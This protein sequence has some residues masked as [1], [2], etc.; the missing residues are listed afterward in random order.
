VSLD[1]ILKI[2]E[3]FGVSKADAEVYIYLAK[4]APTRSADLAVAFGKTQQQ[5][6]PVLSR[7]DK[8][9][10]VKQTKSRQILF[11]ALTFEELLE[12]YVRF[13]IEQ[14][15]SIEETKEQLLI[16]QKERAR[17]HGRQYSERN[18]PRGP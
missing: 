12:R 7:L 9:G 17:L 18:H 4:R 14:A 1:R 16:D 8:K 15:K 6:C 13:N 10:I 11:S 3:G 5:I 2:L